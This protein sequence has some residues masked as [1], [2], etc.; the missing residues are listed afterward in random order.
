MTTTATERVTVDIPAD[1][2]TA[3]RFLAAQMGRGTSMS[4]LIRAAIRDLVVRSEAAED[5]ADLAFAQARAA[6]AGPV[7][8][9]DEV[10]SMLG[11]K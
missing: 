4:S 7:H 8:T 11:L 2:Y 3:L 6:K 1:D 10:R 5:A 9:T